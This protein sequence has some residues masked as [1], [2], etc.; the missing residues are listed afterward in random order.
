MPSLDEL[1][2]G[3][4]YVHAVI[5]YV[6]PAAP[7]GSH[8]DTDSS[9]TTLPNISHEMRVADLRGVTDRLDIE[10]NGFALVRHKSDVTEF[11]NESEVAGRYFSEAEEIVRA[12]T[13]A[14]KVIVFGQA[15]RNAA[16]GMPKGTRG[17]AYN[18]HVDYNEHTMRAVAEARIGAE[19]FRRRQDQRIVLINLWR[20]ITPV[21]SSPLAVCD[22]TSVRR[23]DLVHG[24]IGGQ[25][26]AKVPGA[27]GFNMAYN[28]GHRW[29]YVSNMQPDEVLAFKL[30]D[31][32][33]QRPQW[34]AHTAFE[35]PSSRPGAKPRQSIEVRTLSFINI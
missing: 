10:T 29:Y 23:D 26:V 7:I 17:P 20:P 27:A 35:D 21:E 15:I 31:T 8:H 24:P 2:H 34:T 1:S 3:Q 33:R 19:E 9:K 28:P 25:S 16:P 18:A 32:D 30:C 22:P 14:D 13:G 6:D 12:L 11:D 5:N 4:R